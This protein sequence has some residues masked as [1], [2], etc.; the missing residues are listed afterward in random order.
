MRTDLLDLVRLG[1]VGLLLHAP[2]RLEAQRSRMAM[3][4]QADLIFVGTVSAV[5]AAAM[6]GVPVSQRTLSVRV[7]AVLEKPAAVRLGA[8]DTVT[9]EAAAP[10]GLAVGRQ[11]T[12]YTR[13]WL[14]GR[15][16]AVQE[17]GHETTAVRRSAAGLV[18]LQDSV[19]RM[20]RQVSDS[21]LQARIRAADM[22]VVGRVETIQPAS[23][24]AM[25]GGRRRVTEH[26]PAWQEAILVVE[27]MIKGAAPADQRVVVRFPGSLDVAWRTMP[28][29]AVG[30]EG[31]FL[32]RRDRVSGS[33]TAMMAGRQ[34][35]AYAAL[36]TQDVLSKQDAARVQA[37]ARP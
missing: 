19:S 27:T 5:G 7:D 15:G 16:V 12:F 23:L 11:A 17:V 6:A 37:L 35:T 21:T 3:M 20:R 22:V 25:P 33:P 26:D 34:V 36:S 14:F 24:A 8:G 28:R 4:R 13:T 9:V 31:T 30:Q 2:A 18:S 10:E 29:Y 32:L 1:L